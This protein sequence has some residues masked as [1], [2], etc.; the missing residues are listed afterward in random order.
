MTP[1][2]RRS[3]L[4]ALAA[5]AANTWMPAR[6][7]A[8]AAKAMAATGRDFD[9]Q[10]VQKLGALNAD[11]LCER[12]FDS[13]DTASMA[14]ELMGIVGPT[15]LL[16]KVPEISGQSKADQKKQFD[17]LRTLAK[18]KVWLPVAGERQVGEWMDQKYRKESL[19]VD[20]AGLPRNQRT[21]FELIQGLLTG[22]VAAL[23][24]DNPYTFTLAVTDAPE[25]NASVSPGGFIYVTTGMLQD[26]T[27][28]RDD[29][30]LRL[31]H[32]ISHLTRRH[33]LKEIQ[34]KVVDSLT[35]GKSMKP[36]LGF[37][38]EPAKGLETVL[39][40][41]KAT[42][43]MFQRYDQ[44]QELEADACG[45]YLLARQPGIDANAAV[46]RFAA[47]RKGTGGK[48]WD[49]S[50]PAPEERE[51]VMTAQLNPA[52]RARVA[53]MRGGAAPAPAAATGGKPVN[54]AARTTRSDPGTQGVPPTAAGVQAP[55][56]ANP[57]G[58]LLDKIK[59]AVPPTEPGT[60]PAERREP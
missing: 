15:L 12:L 44:V 13:A 8:H 56:N 42:D 18:Q 23:P 9:A 55:T 33:A 37:T 36:L 20:A 24:A 17:S 27:L 10:K 5:L 28:D 11:F 19:V 58:A 29:I 46:K 43:L 30:A 1:R 16:G 52:T 51:M 49:A 21:R 4:A 38:K 35:I 50:H 22:V 26:K 40:T 6:A 45:A 2:F 31:S 32:E 53:Q 54:S 47:A 59:K 57:F 34:V 60:A 3:I 39:G 48:G 7:Q 41:V 14:F 25:S